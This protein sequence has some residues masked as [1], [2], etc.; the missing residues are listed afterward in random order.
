MLTV[1]AVT[2]NVAE[3]APCATATLAGTPAAAEFELDSDTTAPPDG[4]AAVNVTV[5]VPDC[6]LAIVFGLTATPLIAAGSGLMV[7][8]AAVLP[9]A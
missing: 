9:P 5:P 8:V 2:A 1:P 4:A 6:V 7:T 3:V